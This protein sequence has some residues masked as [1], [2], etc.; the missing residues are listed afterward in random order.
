MDALLL[1]LCVC[2]LLLTVLL[3]RRGWRP[4]K[5]QPSRVLTVISSLPRSRGEWWVQFVWMVINLRFAFLA[6]QPLS[7]ESI[8]KEYSE[9]PGGLLTAWL[10]LAFIYLPFLIVYVWCEFQFDGIEPPRSPATPRV[11]DSRPAADGP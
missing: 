3:A 2:M 6:M 8:R 7:D 5:I 1:S 10:V 11:P 4:F 9:L